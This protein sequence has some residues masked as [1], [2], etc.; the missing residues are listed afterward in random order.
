M[1]STAQGCFQYHNILRFQPRPTSYFT[2]PVDTD[3]P[4]SSFRILLDRPMLRNIKKCTVEEGRKR[5][6][7]Q[8]W[9]V[10]LHELDKFIGLVV[11]DV[12]W[13]LEEKNFPRGVI[14]V[15]RGVIGGK[16]SL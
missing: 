1:S 13:T 4:V 12:V 14:G 5:T 7:D 10:S 15:V 2:S 9:D 8:I 6:G 11:R 16:T 3:S